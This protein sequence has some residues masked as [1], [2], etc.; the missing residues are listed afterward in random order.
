MCALF[1]LDVN[2]YIG[3]YLYNLYHTTNNRNKV[4]RLV[5]LIPMG[6]FLVF[7]RNGPREITRKNKFLSTDVYRHSGERVL[8]LWI[9][10]RNAFHRP[11]PSPLLPSAAA[12]P[13]SADSGRRPRN[14]RERYPHVGVV[15]RPEAIRLEEQPAERA[16]ASAAVAA[17]RSAAAAHSDT[18]ATRWQQRGGCGG[19]GSATALCWR[20][21]GDGAA[22]VAAS[23]AVAAARQRDVGGSLAA[24]QQ[25]RQRQRRLRRCTA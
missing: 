21:L 14:D 16:A 9:V 19:G 15:P 8:L 18:A 17:A 4:R 3:F 22:A 25:R 10:L 23:A 24:A 7:E 13:R 12:A 11:S 5:Q 1:H 2:A 6:T 20:Q